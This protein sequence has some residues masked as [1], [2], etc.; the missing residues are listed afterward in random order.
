MGRDAP[1]NPIPEKY[2]SRFKY[3]LEEYS[4]KYPKRNL[5]I[6]YIGVGTGYRG[7]DIM[8]LTIGDLR[9]AIENEKFVIQEKKQYEAWLTYMQ[10]N[11]NSKRKRPKPREAIIESRLKRLL[12]DFVKG[13]SNSEYAFPSNKTGEHITS[14]SYSDILAEVGRSL[15]LKH[16]SG[17]SMRKTYA[18]RLWESTRN[19]EYVRD[20]LGHTDIETTKKYLGIGD[21]I[22][23]KAARIA[24]DRL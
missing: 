23:V 15:G 12:K 24:D 5:M 16:I 1:A 21:E 20:A 2:Y 18:H 7:Q 3:R 11:P 14:K 13:K 8:D 22:K 10:E 9:N 6:F 19:I 17:H 4:K